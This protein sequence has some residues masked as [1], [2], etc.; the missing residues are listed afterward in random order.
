MPVLEDW[1]KGQGSGYMEKFTGWVLQSRLG[2]MAWFQKHQ[3]MWTNTGSW[4]LIRYRPQ[5]LDA[6]FHAATAVKSSRVRTILQ[7]AHPEFHDTCVKTGEAKCEGGTYNSDPY[8]IRVGYPWGPILEPSL[9][10]LERLLSGKRTLTAM[11]R[12][13]ESVQSPCMLLTH[14]YSWLQ[15][16]GIQFP[17][18]PYTDMACAW[19]A[20]M[21]A[22]THTRINK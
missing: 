22:D 5:H 1:D 7:Q 13:P 9:W 6:Q 21:H 3:R 10:E 18:L 8:D 11:R 4:F 15:L 14:D 20:H 12:S 19:W 17:L 16:Q 2:C